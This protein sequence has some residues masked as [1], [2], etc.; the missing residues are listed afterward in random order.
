MIES[1]KRLQN[2]V[3]GFRFNLGFSGKY[4]HHGSL[5]ENR[6]DDAL[7]GKLALQSIFTL[8]S[9]ASADVW[10]NQIWLPVD[11]IFVVM[12]SLDSQMFLKCTKMTVV[13][14]I[15]FLF[16]PSLSAWNLSIIPLLCRNCSPVI[17]MYRKYIN[18]RQEI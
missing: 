17:H 14:E 13:T 8:V 6:G 11:N 7:I 16:V 1:Q 15:W 18:T 12:R 3:D 4:F 2:Y 5:A 9:A 10:H